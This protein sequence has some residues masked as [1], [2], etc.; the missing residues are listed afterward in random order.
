[1]LGIPLGSHFLIVKEIQ[2][3]VVYKWNV[4]F[5][6]IHLG[7]RGSGTWHSVDSICNLA[8]K[9]ASLDTWMAARLVESIAVHYVYT[10]KEGGLLRLVFAANQSCGVFRSG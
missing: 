3:I 8:H 9:Y 7:A 2:N 1:M 5:S 4:W 6:L 10:G